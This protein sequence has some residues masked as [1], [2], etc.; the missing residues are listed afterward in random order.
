MKYDDTDYLINREESIEYKISD[1][2]VGS[3]EED[4]MSEEAFNELIDNFEIVNTLTEYGR[5]A[6]KQNVKN[7][8]KRIK[9][10]EEENGIL[11]FQNKQVENYVKELKKY[12]KTVSDRIVEYKKNSISKQK[13]KDKIEEL[14]NAKRET[15]RENWHYIYSIQLKILEELLEE[16]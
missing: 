14:K 15:I 11:E 1:T 9:E 7:L 8:Q 10:L 16:K 5:K 2:N 12:N 4:I 3:I 13:V 6:I